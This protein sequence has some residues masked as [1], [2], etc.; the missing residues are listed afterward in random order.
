M[1]N[2]LFTLNYHGKV[3]GHWLDIDACSTKEQ[4]MIWTVHW[5]R[6][7]IF[8]LT[9]DKGCSLPSPWEHDHN[10]FDGAVRWTWGCQT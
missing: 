8:N 7:P 4:G 1:R 6:K 9:A 5:K 3:F 10:W 2:L